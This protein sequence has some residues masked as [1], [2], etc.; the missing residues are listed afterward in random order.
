MLLHFILLDVKESWWF[1]LVCFCYVKDVLGFKM[2]VD[3]LQQG[4]ININ[5]V[6]LVLTSLN[7]FFVVLQ[8]LI[9]VI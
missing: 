8:A 6:I 4:C 3:G 9:K 2:D 1:Y 5:F 7:T